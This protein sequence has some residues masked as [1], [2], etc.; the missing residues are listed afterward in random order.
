MAQDNPEY[1]ISSQLPL[2][3]RVVEWYQVACNAMGSIT[4]DYRTKV[5]YEKV[6]SALTSLFNE[7]VL[8]R[9]RIAAGEMQFLPA[10]INEQEAFADLLLSSSELLSKFKVDFRAYQ[11]AISGQEVDR[12]K[13]KLA[14]TNVL[15][16]ESSLKS[17]MDSLEYKKTSVHFK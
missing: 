13:F 2:R 4:G 14:A 17:I 9:R 3:Q 1:T 16:T 8:Y 15:H 12:V 11:V 6:N 5:G 7:V 10:A